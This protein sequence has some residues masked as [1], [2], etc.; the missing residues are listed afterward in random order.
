M[1]FKVDENLRQEVAVL[2]REHGHD[3]ATVY[4]QNLQGHDDR[5]VAKICREEGRVI[6]TQDLDFSYILNFPPQE[7]AGIV[8]LR[9]NDQSK[10]SVIAVMK[11]LIPQFET[12]SLAGSLWIV[13]EIKIRIHP[14]LSD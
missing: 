7:Y 10:P 5:D 13:D 2:L 14:G 1:L 11:R 6:L 3:A 4:D 12:V 9:L 8:V